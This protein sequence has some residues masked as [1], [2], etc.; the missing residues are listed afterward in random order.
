LL[1]QSLQECQKMK[2]LI[3]VTKMT[4]TITLQILIG[5]SLSKL[6]LIE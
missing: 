3:N 6:N 2:W 5:I 1:L 4:L